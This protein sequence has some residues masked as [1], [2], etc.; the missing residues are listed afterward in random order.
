MADPRTISKEWDVRL[1]QLLRGTSVEP[2]L[3]EEQSQREKTLGFASITLP[4]SEVRG[5]FLSSF[6]QVDRGYVDPILLDKA[7]VAVK[8]LLPNSQ[9]P[10]SLEEAQARSPQDTSS[11][12]PLWSTDPEVLPE[13]LARAKDIAITGD[14]TRLYPFVAGR[15]TTNSTFGEVSKQ[16]LLWIVDKAEVPLG[17]SVGDV[18]LAGL[19]MHNHFVGWLEQTYVD[20][21]V[22]AMLARGIPILSADFSRY[23]ASLNPALIQAAFRL[24]KAW[25][26]APYLD[27]VE[28]HFITGALLHPDGI[29]YGRE[30]GVPS[31]SS[32][33]NMIDTLCQVLVWT[34]LQIDSGHTLVDYLV[35]GDDAL[36]QFSP[37]LDPEEVSAW[38]EPMG[39][40]LNADKTMFHPE[41]CHFLQNLHSVGYTR[42]GVSVGVRSTHRMLNRVLMPE[43]FPREQSGALASVAAALKIDKCDTHPAFEEFVKFHFSGDKLVRER[44]LVS[45]LREAGG[46]GV[47]K[48][49]LKIDSFSYTE[50][51]PE[52]LEALPV[53][54]ILEKLRLRQT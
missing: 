25:V 14:A 49:V 10:L 1:Q 30:G 2:L 40:T 16:R 31:G 4:W 51:D 9:Q 17:K 11:G 7:V 53:T 29:T 3:L 32:L 36:V 20:R 37:P 5:T 35:M 24:L 13:Y 19:R 6:F 47:V 12:L 28:E 43:R 52:V 38:M 42:E 39:L 48:S 15:R 54:H 21:A 26:R 22:S 27:V 8:K 23:D 46:A 45:L 33:T 34:M 44:S 18:V 50:R 41:H